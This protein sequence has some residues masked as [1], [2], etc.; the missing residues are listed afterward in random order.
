MQA[1]ITTLYNSSLYTVHDFLCRCGACPMSKKEY[2]QQFA[3]A[4]IRKGNFQFKVF[5]NDLDAYHG[6]FLVCKPGY[7]QQVG[8][9][10]DLP[11]ECTIFSLPD[12]Y[13]ETLRSQSPDFS[14]FFNNQDLQSIL[15]K[16][17]PETEFLH[18]MLFH[19][20]HKPRFQRLFIEQLITDLFLTVFSVSKKSLEIPVLNY[21]QKRHY[22]PMIESVKEFVNC[23]YLEDISLAKLAEIGHMSSFHFNRL[24]KQM[25]SVTPYSYLL[26]VRLAQA[27]LQIRNTN[28]PVTTVAFSSG[29]NSLEHFSASYKNMYG[30]SPSEMRY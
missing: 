22:L 1:D 23:H 27:N 2:Q 3:I 11:D 7:E 20:L 29:F 8:H 10:H 6:L 17:N 28:L 13:L 24:F 5:K 15:I 21:K 4:Y 16:A 9:M 18:H 25:T 30:V 26:Q 19:E 14:W 12:E